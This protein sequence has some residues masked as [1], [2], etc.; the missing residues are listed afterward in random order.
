MSVRS[1]LAPGITPFADDPRWGVVERL[2]ASPGFAKSGRLTQFLVYVCSSALA[3]HASEINES[4]VGVNVFGRPTGYSPTEDSIVRSHARLLRKRLDEYFDGEGRGEPYRIRIPK[5]GYVPHFE[6]QSSPLPPETSVVETRI[7]VE[8]LPIAS[9]RR[10]H[11]AGT[12]Y[13][14]LLGI[15]AA[16]VAAFAWQRHTQS[17]EAYAARFWAGICNA[18]RTTLIVPSDTALVSFEVI[19]G[20]DVGLREY[21]AQDFRRDTALHSSTP[22]DRVSGLSSLPYTNI[23][24]LQFCWRL[25]LTARADLARTTIRS[26]KDLRSQDLKG[27]NVI[28]IGAR[29]AN[30][31]VELFDQSNN[32]QGL[33]DDRGDFVLNR[34]PKG[35]ERQMYQEGGTPMPGE[36]Y[37]VVSYV[38]GLNADDRALVISGTTTAGTEAGLDFLLNASAFGRT[39]EEISAGGNAT[40]WFEILLRAGSVN[41]RA[42]GKAEVVSWRRRS[43]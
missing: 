36:S 22:L 42:P 15:V 25:A 26:A 41:F 27:S 18:A 31:W 37:A 43:R 32:F 10:W 29:R 11:L 28:L 6:E 24:D 19:T 12:L 33:H 38:P 4:Q 7:H 8:P 21:V 40:P 30:P 2:I 3:G 5:G 16:T 9:P 14:A 39:L 1:N 34:A 13:F 35:A 17:P 23:V 20:R